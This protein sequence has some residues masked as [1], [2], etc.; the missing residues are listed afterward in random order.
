MNAFI[1]KLLEVIGSPTALW[2]GFFLLCLLVATKIVFIYKEVAVLL[3]GRVKLESQKLQLEIRKLKAELNIDENEFDEIAA[4]AELS[5]GGRW[6]VT[7]IN[8]LLSAI[9]MGFGA[10]SIAFSVLV[11][12]TT[13]YLFVTGQN[14]P[15][16]NDLRGFVIAHVVFGLLMIAIA[17]IG[18]WLVR[19]ARVQMNYGLW[20]WK[21]EL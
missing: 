1:V 5:T 6:L 11:I 20:D 19:V 15:P 8:N 2:I 7:R 10:L 14:P 9:V 17:W 21:L 13:I 3:T 12:V 4:A 18:Y 16:D